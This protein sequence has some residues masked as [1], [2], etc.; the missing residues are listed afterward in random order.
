MS[1]IALKPC[2]FAGQKF[3]IGESV[4]GEY[5]LPGAAKNLVKMQI[6]SPADGVSVAPNIP[7]AK[8]LNPAPP[9]AVTI[10][11]DEGDIPLEL[12]DIGL[13][14]IFDVLTANVEGAEKIIEVMEDG[15]ALILLH[16]VDGR[17]GVKTAAE[18]RAKSLEAE[19][20][21]EAEEAE[22]TAQTEEPEEGSE[23]SAG[24]E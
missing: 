18:E 3:K 13:Q 24:E 6:I 12:T 23:E 1:Y 19:P 16:V 8:S 10:H 4:P 2:T 11:A 14:Q 20:E 7:S 17:K 9:I 22:E 21:E 15:D 5:I